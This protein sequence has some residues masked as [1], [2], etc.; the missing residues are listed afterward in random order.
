M[1]ERPRIDLDGVSL[2]D[3]QNPHMVVAIFRYRTTDGLILLIPESAEVTVP[4]DQIEG[5]DLDLRSGALRVRLAE[6]YVRSQNWLR[7]ARQL[8][9]RW[10]DRFLMSRS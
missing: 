10:T 3:E 2:T 1:R 9:G 5:A 8:S 7:G 6:G 4:W